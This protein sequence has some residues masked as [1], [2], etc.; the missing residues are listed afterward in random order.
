MEVI[1]EEQDE[2]I[3]HNCVFCTHSYNDPYGQS[4]VSEAMHKHC[5]HQSLNVMERMTHTCQTK[6]KRV[7]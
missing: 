7:R 4:A 6:R 2:Q 5:L 1:I 3:I